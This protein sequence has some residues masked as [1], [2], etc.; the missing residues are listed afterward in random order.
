MRPIVLRQGNTICSCG[1]SLQTSS[2]PLRKK[3]TQGSIV[4]VHG[5]M[6]NIILEYSGVFYFILSS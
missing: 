3:N 6:E 4:E 1:K 2:R 5:T